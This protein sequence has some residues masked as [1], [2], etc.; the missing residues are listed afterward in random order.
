MQWFCYWGR[1]QIGG[2]KRKFS[3]D[4]WRNA[5]KLTELGLD[6]KNFPTQCSSSYKCGLPT[7]CPRVL[8]LRIS[9]SVWISRLLP[10]NSFN[11]P[12]QNTLALHIYYGEGKTISCHSCGTE[13]RIS[14]WDIREEISLTLWEIYC[15]WIFI[16][17][18]AFE[19][20]DLKWKI[21]FKFMDVREGQPMIKE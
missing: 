21:N 20:Q 15:L 7:T 5:Q 9:V 6:R 17:N 3:E 14:K 4:H 19:Q 18:L 10:K 12:S 16:N 13:L 2:I 1:A 11:K 8:D